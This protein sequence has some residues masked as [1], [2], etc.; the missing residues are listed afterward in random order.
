MTSTTLISCTPH[1]LVEMIRQVVREEIQ[2]RFDRPIS[3]QEV[4]ELFGVSVQTVNNMMR[5][6]EIRRI[7]PEG[8]HPKFSLNQVMNHS[9]IKSK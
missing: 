7:N 4:A 3:K 6:G 5:K 9:K 2:V 8:G 1:E